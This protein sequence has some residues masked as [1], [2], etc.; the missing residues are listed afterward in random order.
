MQDVCH[1]KFPV[2]GGELEGSLEEWLDST[3][4]FT[5]GKAFYFSFAF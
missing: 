4:T 2:G 5:W 1:D 3:M